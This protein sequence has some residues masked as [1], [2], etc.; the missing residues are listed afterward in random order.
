MFES[1][2]SKSPETLAPPSGPG[3]RTLERDLP[4][5]D[6]QTRLADAL[7]SGPQAEQFSAPPPFS[8]FGF[9]GW[10]LRSLLVLGAAGLAVVATGKSPHRNSLQETSNDLPAP[11]A[12]D[13]AI[14][15][16]SAAE[17]RAPEPGAGVADV[18]PVK[19]SS[20]SVRLE[21]IT[22]I[23]ERFAEPLQHARQAA[24]SSYGSGG[25]T[26]VGTSMAPR[27]DELA[28]FNPPRDRLDAIVPLPEPSVPTSSML[29][30]VMT[31][32]FKE[33]AA[34]R[35]ASLP[36]RAAHNAEAAAA[37]AVMPDVD[38]IRLTLGKY[39]RA[40]KDLD[41]QAAARIWPSVDRRALSR[42]FGSIR[43]QGLN[44]EQCDINVAADRATVV[45]RGVLQIVPRVGHQEPV[46]SQQE[47]QFLMHKAD[48]EWKIGNVTATPQ[49][50][51]GPVTGSD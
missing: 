40:Y 36:E 41:V 43:S 8:R 13:G 31:P 29:P 37:P 50:R 16:S 6:T 38:A 2:P 34:D 32:T 46:R 44:L 18:L 42:A 1:G 4:L 51:R 30:P 11:S 9:R 21:T 27:A 45:C 14:R 10:R 48:N 25:A 23:A 47:W 22:V 24:D 3:V 33:P 35:P 20:V 26:P 28:A 7:A 5:H 39:E 12:A 49:S 17:S 19:G 15:A